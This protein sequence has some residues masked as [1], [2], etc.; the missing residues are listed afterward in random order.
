M[1]RGVDEL[2]SERFDVA[3]VGG[4]I[5]GAWI[6]LRAAG[7]GYRVALVE[8]HD[9]GAATSANSLKILHGGLRYLQHLDFGRMRASIRARRELA[10]YTPRLV[11]PLPCLMPLRVTG[12]RSPWVLGPALAANDLISWDRNAG[13]DPAVR[14]PRGKLVGRRACRAQLGRLAES[15]AAAGALWWDAVALDTGRLT[16]EPVLAAAAAG[17]VVANRVEA[18]GL[19]TQRGAVAGLAAVDRVSGRALEIRSAVVVDAAGPWAGRLS[20][21][22]GLPTGFLPPAWIGALN[23]VLRRGLGL[24]SAIALT[25]ASK[26]AGGSALLRRSAREIFVVPWRGVTMIGTDYFPA[27]DRAAAEVGPPRGAANA[28]IEAIDRIAPRAQVTAADV[29]LVHWGLLPLADAADPLPSKSAVLA[30]GR[31]ETGADGLV[32]VIGEKLTSAPVLA[33][34]VLRRIGQSVPLPE[35]ASARPSTAS[36]AADAS[37]RA[38]DAPACAADPAVAERLIARYGARAREVAAHADARPALLRRVHASAEVL[39]VEI[40]HAIREESALGL[41]DIVLRRVGLGETGHPGTDVLRGCAELVAAE[42][43]DDPA[44]SAAA[45]AAIEAWFARGRG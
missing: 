32:V 4:G 17:A 31:H 7:A 42:R 20:A 43:G 45:V 14:L 6:A 23:L 37:V 26:A 39:G 13:L 5:H 1:R 21:A 12:V 34:R 33:E 35:R 38:A 18:V 19:L 15:S 8:K 30:S 36:G 2:A 9:F 27:D 41:D 22:S 10:R 3:I 24:D 44:G 40:V 28:F 11:R 16:L 29:A 25:A